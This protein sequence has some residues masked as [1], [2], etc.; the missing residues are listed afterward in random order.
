MNLNSEF[1]LFDKNIK[2]SQ[3]RKDKIL[4]SRNA[5]REKIRSHFKNELK[6]NLPKFMQQGSFT[7]NTALNPIDGNE[8]DIDDGLYLKNVDESDESSWPTPKEAHQLVLD[9][10]FG[11]TQDGC[12]DKTSCIRVVY[13]NF[14]HVDIPVYI[15]KGNHARLANVKNNKWETSDS[16]DFSDWYYTH[17][18][19]DQTNRIVRYLKAWRDYNDYDF[20]SIELTILA[21]E[22]HVQDEDD[23]MS[24]KYTVEKI[25]S[26]LNVY[27][28]VDKPVAPY[29]NLWNEK[30]VDSLIKQIGQLKED[31][32][33]AYNSLSKHRA[34][35]ILIEQFGDRFPSSKDDVKQDNTREYNWS[36]KPWGIQ[37]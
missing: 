25:Y 24:L 14:Y 12:E 21:V 22:N 31:L 20:A 4:A 37:S 6:I 11:H 32:N 27:R 26:Y 5:V 7:I 10:L 29:E 23:G 33:T 19:N 28:R 36:P 1:I 17:R 3:S 8:V 9:A 2:L 30:N 13:R 34:S 16:K 15:M 18:K 35:L